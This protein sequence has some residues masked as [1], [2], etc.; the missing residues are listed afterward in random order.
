MINLRTM[1]LK[2][3]HQGEIADLRSQVQLTCISTLLVFPSNVILVLDI[4]NKDEMCEQLISC[5]E[6]LLTKHFLCFCGSYL[7]C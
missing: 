3:I 7:E 5:M 4:A 2:L 1:F 6:L